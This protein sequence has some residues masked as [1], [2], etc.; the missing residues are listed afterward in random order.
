MTITVTHVRSR[1]AGAAPVVPLT[2]LGGELR[3]APGVEIWVE[4]PGGLMAAFELSYLSEVGA[5]PIARLN[6]ISVGAL[7][8]T[9]PVHRFVVLSSLGRRLRLR[10]NV[11]LFEVSFVA[12]RPVLGVV[13]EHCDETEDSTDPT[14][15]IEP[16]QDEYA[17]R[18]A[19][20]HSLCAEKLT[21]WAADRG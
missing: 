20:L 6:P 18:E 10:V 19:L 13:C 17:R 12:G 16:R 9:G 5:P 4:T 2:K 8:Q 21:E 11:D 14:N 1:S 15:A 3:S 7:F